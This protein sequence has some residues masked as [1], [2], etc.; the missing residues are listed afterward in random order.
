MVKIMKPILI[1]MVI[2]LS[3]GCGVDKSDQKFSFPGDEITPAPDAGDGGGGGNQ[4]GI[5]IL[6]TTTFNLPWTTALPGPV[7]YDGVRLIFWM[8]YQ[9]GMNCVPSDQATFQYLTLD[10]I[11]Q[12]TS[13]S[14]YSGISSYGSCNGNSYQVFGTAIGNSGL[15]WTKSGT[16][17]SLSVRDDANGNVLS[18]ID[19]T[20]ANYGC[21]S[22][23]YFKVTYCGGLYYGACLSTD[24]YQMIRFFSFNSS[25]AM[26][27]AVTTNLDEITYGGVSGI[28]CYGNSLIVVTK[29][30]DKNAYNRF[31]KY[32]LNFNRIAVDSST[33]YQYPSKLQSIIGIATDGTYLYLQ[34]S[35]QNS[36]S[37]ATMTFGKAT[38]GD[39][40]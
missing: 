18:N 7:A 23:D 12:S 36:S 26:Q 35:A 27:S 24:Y 17:R 5:S 15:L 4:G 30:S 11:T 6:S 21:K 37:P 8:P 19:I 31:Y 1:I 22:N 16:I 3:Q 39:L 20:P 2:L 40:Q 33:S 9:S 28:A 14:T 29:R 38:L 32:D 10:F 34:G 13:T 25:G